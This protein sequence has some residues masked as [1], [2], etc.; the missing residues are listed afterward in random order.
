MF[1][2]ELQHSVPCFAGGGGLKSASRDHRRHP[3]GFDRCESAFG[4]CEGLCGVT[5]ADDRCRLCF[6]HVFDD[7]DFFDFSEKAHW[8]RCFGKH[9]GSSGGVREGIWGRPGGVREASWGVLGLSGGARGTSWEGLGRSWGDLGATFKA[10]R[11][12]ID[13][14]IDFERQKGA[15]REAFGEAKWSQNRSQNDPKS[16]SIFK[17]EK[18]LFKTVLGAS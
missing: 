16:K 1:E 6:R 5:P 14:L 13:F 7:F 15:K 3:L 4:F 2:G 11:F 9:L 17:S 10:V 8:A 18:T 12:R